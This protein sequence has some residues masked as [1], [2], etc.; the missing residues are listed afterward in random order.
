M[1]R[2]GITPKQFFTAPVMPMSTWVLS[3][4]RSMTP[5][6]SAA[7]AVIS[8]RR[9]T[10]PWGRDTCRTDG[11]THASAPARSAAA[12]MPVFSYR[13][14]STPSRWRAP[15]GLS[16]MTAVPPASATSRAT[17]STT[18]GWVQT[19]LSGGAAR[20]RLGLSRMRSPGFTNRSMPPMSATRRRMTASAW[21]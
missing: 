10:L 17:A 12:A 5:S 4:H 18:A 1:D 20:S 2:P 21:P 7:G 8:A 3:L 11:S 14:R 15:P 19:A 6:H 16:A 9:R 13:A